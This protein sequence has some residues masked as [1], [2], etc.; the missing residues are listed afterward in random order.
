[1]LQRESHIKTF[2]RN[3]VLCLLLFA[4]LPV[5]LLDSFLR[6]TCINYILYIFYSALIFIGITFVGLL[7]LLFGIDLLFVLTTRLYS[8][9]D[10]MKKSLSA[11]K[12]LD[13]CPIWRNS[14]WGSDNYNCRWNQITHISR[15]KMSKSVLCTN[16]CWIKQ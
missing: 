6:I 11:L 9:L 13:L 15:V 12:F 1:M 7:E 4:H 5:V 16:L 10:S 3:I 8:E 2:V 14:V